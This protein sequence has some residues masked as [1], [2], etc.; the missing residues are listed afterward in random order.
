MTV[1]L[2]T[3]CQLP[4]RFNCRLSWEFFSFLTKTYDGDLDNHFIYGDST[5]AYSLSVINAALEVGAHWLLPFV[6]QCAATFSARQ[7]L[8]FLEGKMGQYA[9][10]SL[11]A[12]EQMVHGTVSI[13]RFLIRSEPCLFAGTCERARKMML[14]HLLDDVSEGATDPFHC[15]KV[16]EHFEP[17]PRHLRHFYSSSLE[18]PGREFSSLESPGSE[19]SSVHFLAA[20]VGRFNL[21]VDMGMAVHSLLSSITLLSC[22]GV[23]AGP[24]AAT[25]SGLRVVSGE[26]NQKAKFIPDV[27]SATQV[28]VLDGSVVEDFLRFR[29]REMRTRPEE[30]DWSLERQIL[31]PDIVGQ[32]QRCGRGVALREWGDSFEPLTADGL[33]KACLEVSRA[34]RHEAATAF[35]NELPGVFGLQPWEAMK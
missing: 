33:C 7:L 10:K 16:E 25:I 11:A 2:V 30:F 14:F 23:I 26:T 21:S 22:D 29:G 6:Y 3:S 12:H 4:P 35:W 20:N 5:L 31:D 17:S 19:S 24:A 32:H 34:K 8:S 18:T 13:Q 9:L 1:V 15:A 27:S 28:A